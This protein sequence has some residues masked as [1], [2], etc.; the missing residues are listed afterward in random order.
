MERLKYI[1]VCMYEKEWFLLI[2]SLNYNIS[3]VNWYL[4]V[5]NKP[6][7]IF[8]NIEVKK[9]QGKKFFEWVKNWVQCLLAD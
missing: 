7:D 5:F 1:V 3:Y 4:S 9:I 2:Y 8:F 6:Q